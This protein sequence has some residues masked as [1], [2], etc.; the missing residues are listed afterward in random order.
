MNNHTDMDKMDIRAGTIIEVLDFPEAPKPACKLVIDFGPEIG[1]KSTCTA[2]TKRYSK[3]DLV[4]KRVL[5]GEL[6]FPERLR[7]VMSLLYPI[8]KPDENGNVVVVIRIEPTSKVP[9][10]GRLSFDSIG[11]F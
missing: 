11:T 8:P 1:T 6:N 10:G 9:N 4:G 3:D 7:R 2:I 5:G